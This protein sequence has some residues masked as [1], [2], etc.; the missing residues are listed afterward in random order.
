M[1]LDPSPPLENQ[2]FGI[3]IRILDTIQFFQLQFRIH[4]GEP[5]QQQGGAS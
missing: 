4:W 3:L 1:D 2:E 5:E